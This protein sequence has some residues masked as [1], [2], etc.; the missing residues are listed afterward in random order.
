LDP[1]SLTLTSL[2]AASRARTS[3][4]TG[5]ASSTPLPQPLLNHSVSP[6][7]QHSMRRVA[8]AA[9]ISAALVMSSEENDSV[10]EDRVID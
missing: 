3:L 2:L 7:S 5:V 4:S 10:C 1:E 8:L 9:I 6:S